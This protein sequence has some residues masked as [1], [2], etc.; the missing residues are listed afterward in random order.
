MYRTKVLWWARL[1]LQYKRCSL[2]WIEAK[3]VNEYSMIGGT[4]HNGLHGQN[5][6]AAIKLLVVL[7]RYSSSFDEL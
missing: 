5:C 7:I 6:L 1:L 2:C 4:L 3:I